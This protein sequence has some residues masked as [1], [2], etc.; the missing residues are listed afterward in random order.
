LLEQTLVVCLGEFGRAPLVALEPVFAGS[1]PGRKH[2]AGAYTI[3][4]ARAGVAPGSRLELLNRKRRSSSFE[5]SY[6]EW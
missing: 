4:M 1:S 3:V 5:S 6:R 2:W